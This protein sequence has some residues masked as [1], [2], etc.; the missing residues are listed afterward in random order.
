MNS[1]VARCAG[2]ALILML[3]MASAAATPSPVAE[4]IRSNVERLTQG[5]GSEIDGVTVAAINLVS[6][7]YE[8]RDF[9]PLWARPAD[10]VALLTDMEASAAEGLDPDDFHATHL[11]WMWSD[12]KKSESPDPRQLADLD[13]LL[14]D[15]LLRLG[16]QLYWG[17]VT[18]ERLDPDWNFGRRMPMSDPAT[19]IVEAVENGRGRP[20]ISVAR[21]KIGPYGVQQHHEDV[22]SVVLPRR[23]HDDRN[24]TGGGLLA[25][26][27]QHAG[28]DHH[29][30]DRVANERGAH[31]SQRSRWATGCS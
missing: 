3:A 27:S 9:E 12:L 26:A 31:V 14:T 30:S 19:A 6:A 21:E 13:V 1:L 16:Y 7:V 10:V 15:G 22:G 2:C 5:V 25:T 11:L 29:S 17:K 24:V 4:A 18:A 8:G 28:Q 20:R 23:R